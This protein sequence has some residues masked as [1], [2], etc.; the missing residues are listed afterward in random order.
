MRRSTRST[1]SISTTTSSSRG[2]RRRRT[3]T[4]SS[5]PCWRR[6]G[7]H[8]TPGSR[9]RWS[10]TAGPRRPSRR[11][12]SSRGTSFPTGG[13]SPT[14]PGGHG[15][16]RRRDSPRRT[17]RWWSRAEG[18]TLVTPTE[19]KLAEHVGLR[20]PRAR[21]LRPRRHRRGP[22]RAGAAVYARLRGTAH[23][24]RRAQGTGGQAGQS[25]RIENY[26]GFPDGVSGAQLTER[27]RR[28]ARQF[29]AE[30]L[31]RARWSALEVA[32]SA[33]LPVRRRHLV[34]HAHRG[35]GHRSLV[36][37]AG[38]STSTTYG[39]RCVLR[40]GRFEAATCAG[41]EVYIVGGANSAGPGRPLLRALRAPGAPCSS[42]APTSAGPCR[43]I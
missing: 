9:D 42:A 11:G 28:Q 34:R 41:D 16:S 4:R 43:T 20:Q 26:L 6:A 25:S 27:A 30:F 12:S 24:A 19:A 8:P 5:T 40:L 14:S 1:W 13:S 36:P 15:C 29:G 2:V 17:Y 23:G 32:G 3:S 7:R 18:K 22:G 31:T 39:P 21:L 35:P 38:R 33:R 37:A 10:V